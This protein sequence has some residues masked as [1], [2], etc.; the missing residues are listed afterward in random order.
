MEAEYIVRDLINLPPNFL[1]PQILENFAKK[2]SI[3]HGT[4]FGVIKGKQLLEENFPLIFEVGKGSKQKPRLIKLDHG[5]KNAK[6]KIALI[7][8]GVC[9]DSGGL[10]LKSSEGMRLMKK[11]MAGAAAV[12]GLGHYLL[13]RR[14]N[15]KLQIL[16]PCVENMV[17][18]NAYR[19]GDILVARTGK[20]IEIQNTDAEGRLIIAD[21]LALAAE[22]KPDILVSFASLTGAARV[23][24]GTDLTPFYST[25]ENL[26]RLLKKG[27]DHWY[28]PLWQMPFYEY[29]GGMLSSEF[30]DLNNA[31]TG[32]L[33]GSI[34]AALFLKS[35]TMN[36]KR[37]LHF[38]I[39]GWNRV[40][41]PGRSVG[42]ILQGARALAYAIE[43]LLKK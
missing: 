30:A 2:F 21:A 12:L 7:G 22:E 10:N 6:L 17:S 29:Y 9:F 4:K 18:G 40:R 38:D 41:K 11:D 33:A 28:D 27:G 15:I 23:A 14:V 43:K 37:F 3:F 24:L 35:F 32:G 13:S 42:G 16:I 26:S 34:T 25:D 19:P 20:S 31:P 8:K 5:P 36:H 1:G 39:F